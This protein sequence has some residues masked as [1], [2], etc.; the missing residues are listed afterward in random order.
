MHTSLLPLFFFFFLMIRPPPRSTLFPY[1]TLF[2]SARR[3]P[4]RPR[5]RDE[6]RAEGGASEHEGVRRRRRH[7][8]AIQR[9]G[10]RPGHLSPARPRHSAQNR[11]RHEAAGEREGKAG[12]A[13]GTR[14]EAE[15]GA[16]RE[17]G[18][19]APY[20]QARTCLSFVIA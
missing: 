11:R 14:E 17:V 15:G 1:T 10:R 6:D 2:R 19:V 8:A 16:R 7:A 5:P 3:L 9:A 13:R 20:S 4:R 18:P 12:G